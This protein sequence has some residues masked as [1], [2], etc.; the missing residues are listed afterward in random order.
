VTN[1][2]M[3]GPDPNTPPPP[4]PGR[5]LRLALIAS[6]ALN[7]LFLGLIAGGAMTAAHRAPASHIGPDLRALWRA[8]PDD[9]RQALRERFRDEAGE[10]RTDRGERRARMAEREAELLALLRAEVFDAAAFSSLLE[11]QR[12][13]VAMR[14]EMAQSL[15][16]ERLA[17][18]TRAERA[19]L[20][21]RY[22][23]RRA[24]G[25]GRR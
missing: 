21:E 5:G 1:D 22:E 20:A 15:L 23:S 4:R 10:P 9:T 19:A 18:F 14:S 17:Q 8:L 2:S 25:S 24:R 12:E 3:T 6:L 16:V 7:L 11:S 13:G